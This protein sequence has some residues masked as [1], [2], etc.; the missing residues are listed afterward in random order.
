MT[1]K[2]FV[3]SLLTSM[4]AKTKSQQITM[5]LQSIEKLLS[6]HWS[7]DDYCP[8]VVWLL[9]SS[10]NLQLLIEEIKRGWF[11]IPNTLQCED[12]I[13]LTNYTFKYLVY[14]IKFL[15][16]EC[17]FQMYS[18]SII[19]IAVVLDLVSIALLLYLP[20]TNKTIN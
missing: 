20:F 19:L 4:I 16:L 13:L 10:Q 17:T 1:H 5:S 6:V 11:F 15:W 14:A 7:K 3:R 9:L 2:V 18:K 8:H 12:Y